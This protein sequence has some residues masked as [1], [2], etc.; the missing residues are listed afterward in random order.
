MVTRL[1]GV[2]NVKAAV[3]CSGT[4]LDS[5]VIIGEVMY[6]SG[7]DGMHAAVGLTESLK[8]LGLHFL[9]FKTGTP[10]RLDARSIDFPCWNVRTAKNNETVQCG[11]RSIS[12]VITP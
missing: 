11:Y 4:Y 8:K 6:S 7:P 5:R 2:W 10:P 3:I 1:S 9:R 12:D